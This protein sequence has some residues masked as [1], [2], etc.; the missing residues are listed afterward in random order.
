MVKRHDH[1]HRYGGMRRDAYNRLMQFQ[2]AQ[3]QART[4]APAQQ[5]AP[6][7][8]DHIGATSAAADVTSP[9]AHL[10]PDETGLVDFDEPDAHSE[11]SPH[12]D[13]CLVHRPVP[14]SN[15]GRGSVESIF[16]FPNVG[17]N[18]DHGSTID[19][20][21]NELSGC[22]DNPPVVRRSRRLR[23]LEQQPSHAPLPLPITLQPPPET[24][25][26]TLGGSSPTGDT[27]V[28]PDMS[29][30]VLNP[31]PDGDQVI[32]RACKVGSGGTLHSGTGRGIS[33]SDQFTLKL[34]DLC[35]HPAI[36]GYLFDQIIKELAEARGN[37]VDWGEIT[38]LRRESA[39]N[40]LFARYTVPRSTAVAVEIEGDS[41]GNTV[42][43]TIV[44]NVEDQLMEIL[45]QPEEFSKLSNLAVSRECYWDQTRFPA[46][47]CEEV[48][49]GSVVQKYIEKKQLTVFKDFCI[50]IILYLDE[51][52]VTDNAR[53][54]MRP[55]IM[56]L[57]ILSHDAR[58]LPHNTRVV[59]YIPK[60]DIRSKAQK[61]S[62]N[63]RKAGKGRGVRNFHRCFRK[64]I[65]AVKEMQESVCSK[66][67]VI[68]I[69]DEQCNV[70]L[71]CPIAFCV[72]DG[73]EL[74][75]VAGRYGGYTNVR[76][77]SRMCNVSFAESDDPEFICAFRSFQLLKTRVSAMLDVR[78]EDGRPLGEDAT[79]ENSTSSDQKKEDVAFLNGMSTHKCYNSLWSADIAGQSVLPLP[80]DP[81]HMFSTLCRTL[82]ELTMACLPITK[83]ATLDEL[84]GE[85]FDRSSSSGEKTSFPRMHF[86]R[87]FTSV[88]NLTCDE[89]TGTIIALLVL[90]KTERGGRILKDAIDNRDRAKKKKSADAVDADDVDPQAQPK[91]SKR[92]QR[93][94]EIAPTNN[95]TLKEML[96][97][98]EDLLEF[99]AWY[100]YGYPYDR[101]ISPPGEVSVFHWTNTMQKRV[102]FRIRG[103]QGKILKLFPR[104]KGNG[105]KRQK[106]HDWVHFPQ[107]VSMYGLPWNWDTGWGESML[108]FVAKKPGSKTKERYKGSMVEKAND[109]HRESSVIQNAMAHHNLARYHGDHGAEADNRRRRNNRQDKAWADSM[110]E[111]TVHDP[112]PV[113]NRARWTLWYE[114]G[115]PVFVWKSNRKVPG[116]K[117]LAPSVID[118][119]VQT[120]K[121]ELE[122]NLSKIH[123]YTEIE[124]VTTT[125][126]DAPD[127]RVLIRSHPN[128]L[129]HGP[130][131]D[132]CLIQYTDHYRRADIPIHEDGEVPGK[133]P[134][135]VYPG[136]VLAMFRVGNEKDIRVVIQQCN[137][138]DHKSDS[139]LMEVWDKQYKAPYRNTRGVLLQRRPSYMVV[140]AE[141][142]YR[143]VYVVEEFPEVVCSLDD[144]KYKSGE[145]ST[146]I[147]MLRNMQEYWPLSFDRSVQ[148]E[149]PDFWEEED[150]M[151]DAGDDF[152]EI[153]YVTDEEYG[154]EAGEPSD[155]DGEDYLLD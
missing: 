31:P 69:G 90:V 118:F 125:P 30:D 49:H 111:V 143:R 24:D 100:K 76:C 124:L 65:D 122:T 130:W 12:R 58:Y 88:T 35:D 42:I 129:Q 41:G 151:D 6:T 108:R 74:D 53:V 64:I 117:E 80:H 28:G 154:S 72:G 99:H 46:G 119:L 61:Q 109:K 38:T 45:S 96:S 15:L 112:V 155:S 21:V 71:H 135:T 98:L 86:A 127:G 79:Y 145:Q 102:A 44:Y 82:F 104:K 136:K 103:I 142:I 27:S 97:L 148:L 83:R 115:S 20:G 47:L 149:S 3:Q 134:A 95:I 43:N 13:H 131:Y 141:T 66:R 37:H 126:G 92:S 52:T 8:G 1:K 107:L 113:K 5:V 10:Q 57:G 59:G 87:G 114:N 48:M 40:A 23:L 150:G 29:L 137:T 18:D 138:S 153:A 101:S 7:V 140:W 4:S 84:N 70:H 139:R 120:F 2:L 14:I 89:V 19:S 60:F 39:M 91:P 16:T 106:F 116:R 50:P 121:T 26:S 25:A 63:S 152:Q 123:G 62:Q 93:L 73:K 144:D 34:M 54:S 67:T 17:I 77:L 132:W 94:D 78:E 128:Y 85:L 33:A 75:I 56:A 147:V 51:I 55:V 105:W 110:A 81:M 9:E 68:Q 11:T 146:R 36:P 133:T 32:N 22:P